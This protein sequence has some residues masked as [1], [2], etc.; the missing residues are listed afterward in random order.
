ML[1]SYPL[2]KPVWCI[3]SR[4]VFSW[5]YRISLDPPYVSWCP[6]IS[7]QL[8]S[9]GI[10][11]LLLLH[12]V[13]SRFLFTFS[14]CWQSPQCWGDL[15]FW[16]WAH[17][18]MADS[19]MVFR[20]SQCRSSSTQTFQILHHRNLFQTTLFYSLRRILSRDIWP[21]LELLWRNFR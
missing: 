15:L 19:Y 1:L 11:S 13:L 9:R 21:H 8:T 2:L 3:S 12:F 6:L 20:F 7:S 5:A 14:H 17:P 18:L 16:Y 10:S 4:I